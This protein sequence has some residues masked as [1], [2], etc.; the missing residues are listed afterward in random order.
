M[1]SG[2][3]GHSHCEILA[4]LRRHHSGKFF[5]LALRF[6][7]DGAPGAQQLLQ[8]DLEGVAAVGLEWR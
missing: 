8:R 1:N 6:H 4:P 7:R 3:N 2:S 5:K